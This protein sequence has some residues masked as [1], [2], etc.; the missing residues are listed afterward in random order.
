MCSCLAQENTSR[1][2]IALAFS[3]FRIP[4]AWSPRD[5][6]LFA[7]IPIGS[8]DM[9]QQDVFHPGL[10]KGLAAICGGC[11]GNSITTTTF[12]QSLRGDFLGAPEDARNW[13]V[14]SADVKSAFHQMRN[15]RRLQASFAFPAVLASEFVYTGKTIDPKRLAAES[16]IYPVPSS[17]PMGFSWAM[18]ICQDVTDHCT[19]AGNADRTRCL[20][21][22]MARDLSASVGR[23][24]T[25]L[26]FLSRRKLHQLISHVCLIAGVRK[27]RHYVHLISL[28]R[29]GRDVLGHELC[30]GTG[31]FLASVRTVARTVSLCA[32]ASAARR[33]SLSGK[34]F[35]FAVMS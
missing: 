26:G 31:N 12:Y 18:F 22:R 14:G 27:A 33:W 34:E 19:L 15:T 20:V 25:F 23:M 4:F 6:C 7:F 2:H 16:L 5:F 35:A 3:I 30:S 32:V 9:P 17:F 13:L 29:D 8:S 11:F 24:L 10:F 1:A 21:A 28:A